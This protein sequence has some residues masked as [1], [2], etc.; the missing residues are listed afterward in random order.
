MLWPS[1]TEERPEKCLKKL[2]DIYVKIIEELHFF[3]VIHLFVR[4]LKTRNRVMNKLSLKAVDL[5]R[6]II[7]QKP[8][9]E[10]W[11]RDFGPCFVKT[12][13]GERVIL[14]W[15][16]NARGDK[17]EKWDDDI[18]I[19]DYVANFINVECIEPGIVLEGGSIESNGEGTILTT[20]SALLIKNRNPDLTKDEIEQ[21]L[22]K[23]L[24][25]KQIVWLRSGLTVDGRN[26]SIQFV[27]RWLNSNT[28]LTTIADDPE[29]PDHAI[30]QE[31]LD[32]LKDLS[33]KQD[34]KLN[35]E[36]ITLPSIKSEKDGGYLPASYT[37]FYI[38]NG[39]VLVPQFNTKSDIQAM[40]LFR[41]YFPGRTI[42]PIESTALAEEHGSIYGIINPWT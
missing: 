6:I 3:E 13:G 24:G 36:T 17:Y 39:A 7:H 15:D 2:E 34:A 16:Y 38:A 21:K 30:L 41:R 9:N 26:G 19:P 5:D 28:I 8:Y 35:V 1:I 4:D 22:N 10:I 40:N 12:G 20:E 23:Y 42:I 25:S 29:H 32:K 37:G 11:V 18:S 33:N 31:N 14:N 27:T